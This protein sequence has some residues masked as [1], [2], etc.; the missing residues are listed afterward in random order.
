MGHRHWTV[1]V[2]SPTRRCPGMRQHKSSVLHLHPQ[3]KGC[4]RSA[5][6]K[7]LRFNWFNFDSSTCT[8]LPYLSIASSIQSTTVHS[9]RVG[10]SKVKLYDSIDT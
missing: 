2:A 3:E 9:I 8:T 6:E 1:G 5:N 7:P 4:G 10:I